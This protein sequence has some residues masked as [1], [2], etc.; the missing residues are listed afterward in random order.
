ME[1]R[2]KT[3]SKYTR[4]RGRCPDGAANPVD[5]YVG[6]RILIRRK[7]LALSQESLAKK[8][9]L[10]FQQV[11]K[12]EKGSNRISASRL[13]DLS[14]ILHVDVNYFFQDMS[15]EIA[16]KSPRMVSDNEDKNILLDTPFE[17]SSE[18]QK[19]LLYYSKIRKPSVSH[20]I[21]NLLQAMVHS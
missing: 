4:S 6:H 20:A 17:L 21:L 3:I 14:Q 18:A 11:Q 15:H 9:G 1:T 13:W 10:T 12:Y 16:G 2:T 7:L 19:I 8:L 5:V